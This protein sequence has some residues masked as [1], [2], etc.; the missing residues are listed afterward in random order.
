MTKYEDNPPT[1]KLSKK[2]P[3]FKA[4]HVDMLKT[5]KKSI[6]HI[7]NGHLSFGH[8][9]SQLMPRNVGTPPTI[10]RIQSVVDCNESVRITCKHVV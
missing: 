1:Q 9:T 7:E 8:H 3:L 2:T 10:I 4:F 6:F 5:N